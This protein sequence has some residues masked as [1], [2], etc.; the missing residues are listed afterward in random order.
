MHLCMYILGQ[1][2]SSLDLEYP[3]LTARDDVSLAVP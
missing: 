2:P 1:S 3:G